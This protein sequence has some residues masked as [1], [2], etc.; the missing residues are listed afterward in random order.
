MAKMKTTTNK[1]ASDSFL[2]YDGPTLKDGAYTALFKNPRLKLGSAGNYYI[3]FMGE[4]AEPNTSENSKYNGAAVWGMCHFQSESEQMQARYNSLLA[5][6]GVKASDPEIVFESQEDADSKKGSKITSIGGQK[7]EGRKVRIIVRTRP[8]ADG[9]AESIDVDLVSPIKTS[10][11]TEDPEVEVE[12]ESE[13]EDGVEYED[14][15]ESED[16]EESDAEERVERAAELKKESLAELKA[17]AKEAEIDIKGLKKAEIIEAIVEWEFSDADEDEDEDEEVDEDEELEEAEEE[18][19]EEDEEDEEE[20][21]DE[22]DPLA[23]LREELSGLDR[24]ALKKR[25]KDAAPEAKVFKSTT[26]EDLV[27]MIVDAMDA[28]PF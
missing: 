19:E 1:N 22:E 11:I 5:A 14:D 6:F 7:L 21:E 2:P 20:E 23:V 8:A 18:D 10:D 4:I 24:T 13:D 16:D 3:N 27:N 25:L 12:V 28:P 17:A 15:N 26:D 9:Y